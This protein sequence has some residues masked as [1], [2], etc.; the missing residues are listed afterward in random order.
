MPDREIDRVFLCMEADVARQGLDREWAGGLVLLETC[1]AP[2][3]GEDD[4]EAV[5]L[6]QRLGVA[7][8]TTVAFLPSEQVLLAQEI[9][10]QRGQVKPLWGALGTPA[11]LSASRVRLLCVSVMRRI[12]S[13]AL[14]SSRRPP[15]AAPAQSTPGGLDRASSIRRGGAVD[16]GSRRSRTRGPRRLRLLPG[17]PEHREQEAVEAEIAGV[18]PGEDQQDAREEQHRVGRDGAR[19]QEAHVHEGAEEGRDANQRPDQQAEADRQLAEDDHLGEPRVRAAVDQELD[20][21]AIPVVGD[22]RLAVRGG[23]RA[24]AVQKPRMP[25]PVSIQA[26]SVNLCQPASSHS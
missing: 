15:R 10:A 23:S 19:H 4:A 5:L 17:R 12:S 9:E 3:H 14:G 11:G 25:V 22:D 26:G 1:P 16:R 21:G 24:R 18:L 20:E 2:H 7:I 8:P 13:R 6:H